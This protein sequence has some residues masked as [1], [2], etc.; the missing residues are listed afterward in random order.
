MVILLFTFAET[1]YTPHGDGNKNEFAAGQY[2]AVKQLTPLTG[3]E[4]RPNCC[5][6]SLSRE[7]TYTPHGDG[8]FSKVS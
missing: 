3:T 8:N 7:T 6:T 2:V 4:T 5:L 1:T